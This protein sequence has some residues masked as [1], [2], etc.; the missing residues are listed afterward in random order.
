MCDFMTSDHACH[1]FRMVVL[2]EA[3]QTRKANPYPKQMSIS[4]RKNYGRKDL[5][6]SPLGLCCQHNGYLEAMEARSALVNESPCY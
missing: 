2:A 1:I 6:S 3:M 4:R 5:P